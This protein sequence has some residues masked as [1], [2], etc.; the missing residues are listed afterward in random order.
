MACGCLSRALQAEH[1]DYALGVG[2]LKLKVLLCVAEHGDDSVV[3]YFDE[4]LAGVHG[5]QDFFALGFFD[6]S[7]DKAADDAKV[8]VGLQQGHFDLLYC[9]LDVLFGD[10]RLSA[11][12]SK[13]VGK[14]VCKFF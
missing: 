12:R 1:K 4:L 9:V 3:N 14:G 5:A 6:G 7:V 11:N 8:Y 10:R 13:N 2:A